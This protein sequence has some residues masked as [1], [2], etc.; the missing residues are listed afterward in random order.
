MANLFQPSLQRALDN[1]GNPVSGAKLYFYETGTST[2]ATVYANAAGTTPAQNPLEANGSGIFAPVYLDFDSTYRVKL[3]NGGGSETYYD[4]DPV[5]GFDLNSASASQAA[6]AASAAAALASQTAAA[7]SA[8]AASTSASSAATARTGAENA[9]TGAE[10]ALSSAEDLLEDVSAALAAG[11]ISDLVGTRIY[12]SR[13]AL[14]ADLVPADNEYALVVGDA[15]AANNDLYQKNGATTTGSWDGPL[16]IFAAASAEANDAADRAETARDELEDLVTVTEGMIVDAEGTPV[17]LFPVA[18][19]GDDWGQNTSALIGTATEDCT[20]ARVAAR[21]RF[22]GSGAC[23]ITIA[24]GTLGGSTADLTYV[25]SYSLPTVTSTGEKEW[26]TDDFG[27]VP[28]L[29]GQHVLFTT[30]S[31]GVAGQTVATGTDR[32]YFRTTAF[33]TGTETFVSATNTKLNAWAAFATPALKVPRTGLVD[34]ELLDDLEVLADVVDPLVETIGTR[35]D[36]TGLFPLTR[37]ADQFNA[38]NTALLFTATEAC[39]L[40]EV[41][42]WTE[43][44]GNGDINL[45]IADGTSDA[46]TFASATALTDATLT[47]PNK[48]TVSQALTAGQHVLLSVPSGG[49][50]QMTTAVT[51]QSFKFAT[52]TFTSGSKSMTTAAN[53]QF[54]GYVKTGAPGVQ[55]TRTDLAPALADQVP[56]VATPIEFDMFLVIGQSNAVGSGGGVV[57]T[58]TV[59]AGVMKQYY[60]SALT[61]KT[62]DPVGNASNN[63]ALPAFALEY[64]RKT[65]R[66]VIFVPAASGST[67]LVAAA[68]AGSGNWSA[69]GTL[70]G[71]AITLLNAAKAAADSAGLAWKFAGVIWCQGEQDAVSI[72]AATITKANYTTEL[73]T[74]LTYLQTETG[75]GSTMPFIISVIGTQ[76]AA[77]GGDT[78]GYQQIRAAQLEFAQGRSNVFIGFAAAKGFVARNRMWDG[79]H[80]N[81]QGYDEMGTHLGNTAAYACAGRA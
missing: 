14:N 67:S 12:T 11:T 76:T 59:P 36:A 34:E 78:S 38:G 72:D 65:G 47:G 44:I 73:G 75:S 63:S 64:W 52:G 41:G 23:S 39:T 43:N 19:T 26:D 40:T 69:T 61:D 27:A 77:A 60:S 13:S 50:N 31:G 9:R 53:T 37:G 46:P 49:V 55:I 35:T 21:I 2:L 28:V 20:L 74:L 71:S 8:T 42:V 57:A 3:T 15:T 6:A 79:V 68:D 70:R 81:A 58:T 22:V 1:N 32:M 25:A 45:V 30:P 56:N 62:A 54:H 33:T 29:S 16:G 48:W 18:S 51:G 66:G 7:S 4:I 24:S 10:T 17:G 5:P 80:Y